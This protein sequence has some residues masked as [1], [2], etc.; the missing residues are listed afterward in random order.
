MPRGQNWK[1]T[2]LFPKK[3]LGFS[4][5]LARVQ[6]NDRIKINDLDAPVTAFLLTLSAQ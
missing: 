3:K 1:L 2:N 6:V 4:N 5:P